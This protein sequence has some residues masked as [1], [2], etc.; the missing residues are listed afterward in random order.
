MALTITEQA[1]GDL[2]GKRFIAFK[3]TTNNSDK[4]ITVGSLGLHRIESAMITGVSM[5]G[6]AAPVLSIGSGTTLELGG[7]Y[8]AA[9]DINL[10]VWGW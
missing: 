2:G 9:D 10:W 6:A 1:R 5:S 4:T 3:V 8:G 7:A